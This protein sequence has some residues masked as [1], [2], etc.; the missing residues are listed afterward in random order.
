MITS[1]NEGFIAVCVSSGAWW[2]W[3]LIR[4]FG[5][6]SWIFRIYIFCQFYRWHFNDF[7]ILVFYCVFYKTLCSD[8]QMC[9]QSFAWFY[10]QWWQPSAE[11]SKRRHAEWNVVWRDILLYVGNQ[12]WFRVSFYKCFCT[13]FQRK[14]LKSCKQLFRHAKGQDHG[15]FW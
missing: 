10:Q 8:K 7:Q 11:Y 2:A 13:L 15:T 6:W 9:A 12:W 1:N 3:S 5:L 4:R 14:K